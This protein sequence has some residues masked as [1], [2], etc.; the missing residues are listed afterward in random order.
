MVVNCPNCGKENKNTNI[1]C[2]FCS[3]QLIDENNFNKYDNFLVNNDG[4]ETKIINISAKNDDYLGKFL[5]SIFVVPWILGGILFLGIGLFFNIYERNQAKGYEKTIGLLIEYNGDEAI[6]EYHVNED[7]YTVSPKMTSNLNIFAEQDTVYYNP[8]NPSESIVY[9]NWS[10]FTVTGFIVAIVPIIILLF[11][12][13]KRK[14]LK[15][16]YNKL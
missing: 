9:T 8:N 13:K 12:N 5:I 1:K 4:I 11:V 7:T 16:K 3:T 6:Y 15:D 2:E 10:I 14:K